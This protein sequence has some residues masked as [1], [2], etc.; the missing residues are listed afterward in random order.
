MSK[1]RH[2]FLVPALACAAMPAAADNH[3]AA[4]DQMLKAITQA[5]EKPSTRAFGEAN[6]R[7][8]RDM[9]IE[10][11]GDADVDFIRGMIPH[12]QGA[13][14]MARILLEH[15]TDPETRALAESIIASQEREIAVMKAWL[16]KRGVGPGRTATGETETMPGM[17]H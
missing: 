7:M 13:V 11:T 2:L 5:G 16:E 8:H 12:H 10:F 6:A 9:N 14:D 15:G 3:G 1:L 17:G 4:R